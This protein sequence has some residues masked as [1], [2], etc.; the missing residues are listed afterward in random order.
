MINKE[1]I[2]QMLWI[3]LHLSIHINSQTSR[4]VHIAHFCLHLIQSKNKYWQVLPKKVT[5]HLMNYTLWCGI[6]HVG[7]R[8]PQGPQ[9]AASH[10]TSWHQGPRLTATPDASWGPWFHQSGVPCEAASQG[11]WRQ[12]FGPKC[13]G[14]LSTPPT[15][16]TPILSFR[17]TVPLMHIFH[18]GREFQSNFKYE[19]LTYWANFLN[20]N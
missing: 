5:V 9:F 2:Y 3:L 15:K 1:V 4:A 18:R 19:V 12:H 7:W 11:P 8:V 14:H 6:A 20:S 13:F 16:I 10:G 17:R